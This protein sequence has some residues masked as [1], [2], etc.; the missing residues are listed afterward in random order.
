M[1]AFFL[2]MSQKI[3]PEKKYDIHD[4]PQIALYFD[5]CSKG[6][7]GPSGAGAVLYENGTEIWSDS[8]FVGLRETN[9][10][11]EYSGLILGLEEALARK[12]TALTVRG[13]SLLVI[14]QMTGK[15]AVSSPRMRKLYDASKT[16]EKKFRVVEY[17]HIYRTN[18]QRADE[19]ANE[20]IVALVL[21]KT[22][23]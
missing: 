3:Y 10:V 17:E 9:N 21:N 6:N 1:N 7:P 22:N 12:I 2:I 13:D 14:N 20:G 19:L 4:I 11:A 23:V 15:Y 18:N 5:G 16:L 8:K